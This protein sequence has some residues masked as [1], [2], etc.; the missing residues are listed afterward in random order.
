VSKAPRVAELTSE[1]ED[2]SVK[3][4]LLCYDAN[5][6]LRLEELL[7]LEGLNQ[8]GE[9]FSDQHP[10]SIGSVIKLVYAGALRFQPDITQEEI[11]AMLGADNMAEVLEL[12]IRLLVGN[13]VDPE[14]E[15]ARDQEVRI[16]EHPLPTPPLT[17][18]PSGPLPDSTWDSQSETSEEQLFESLPS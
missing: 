7:A 1:A 16:A 3:R 18:S 2:G 8:I 4:V 5:A 14:R 6:M 11:G 10:T 12:A 9:R 15:A 17:D 13:S